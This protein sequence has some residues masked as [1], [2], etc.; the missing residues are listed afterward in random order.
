MHRRRFIEAL[1]ATGVL[2][3]APASAEPS[4]VKA[5]ARTA[6]L[7]VLP[8]IEMANARTRI[9]QRRG[10]G[11]HP[12]V[13]AFI[14]QPRLAG[15]QARTVT[16]PNCDTIYSTAFVDL[17]EGPVGLRVPDPGARY[18]SVQILDM[19][20]N[21]TVVLGARTLGGAAGSY[22]L[23]APGTAARDA[24]DL[25]IATPHAWIL[26]RI[27]VDGESDMLAAR[28]VQG[29][30]SLSGPSTAVPSGYVT[31]ASDWPAYFAFAA[32]LLASDPPHFKRGLDAFERVRRACRSGDFARAG[33]SG[34]E[35]QAIDA[36][37]A[38][39]RGIVQSAHNLALVDGWSYP[40]PDL[41]NFGD[42]F[43]FRAVVAVQGLAALPPAEAMYMRAAGDR[44][45]GLFEGNGLYRLSLPQAIPVDG[46]WSLTM[47][48]A[49]PEAQFFLTPNALGRYAIGD[50]TRGLRHESNGA[51]DLWIGRKDPGGE[52]TANWLPAPASG[53]FALTLRAY[54]PKPALL[55]GSYRLPAIAPAEG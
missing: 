35:A 13:N 46:F 48:E 32:S 50:R 7:Y 19:Y 12:P 47:Y 30:L 52:R 55:H 28:Q 10:D 53:P 17:T 2:G 43:T 23:V 37:V 29:G 16:T 4:D 54:L 5:D 36:G 8:L 11:R 24:H 39:A 45:N 51:L 33:Y 15:P 14:H 18:L 21:N 1:G 31:R 34:A 20:T 26:A 49:T 22:R 3:M 42:N 40:R 9:L 41:G 38:E 27:L 6:W 25:E 44:G